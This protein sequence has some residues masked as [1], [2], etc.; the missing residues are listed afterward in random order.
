MF[1]LEAL[2]EE[3]QVLRNTVQFL[4]SQRERDVRIS[5]VERNAILSAISDVRQD[6]ATLPIL[7]R[8][9]RSL[10]TTVAAL[11]AEVRTRR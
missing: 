2:K 9:M 10:Q 1:T 4:A 5:G 7:G 3:V 6:I 8:D 11:Q